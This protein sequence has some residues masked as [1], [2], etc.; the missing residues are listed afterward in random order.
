MRPIIAL[1]ACLSP[2]LAALPTSTVAAT[3]DGGNAREWSFKVFL[4]D[5]EIGYHD[6]RASTAGDGQHLESEA[7]FD[8]KILFVNAF[9]Y[10][11]QSRETWVGGC[12]NEI[13]AA[14]RTNGERKRVEGEDIGEQFRL[15]A[16]N[17]T[18][19]EAQRDAVPD[20]AASA[21]TFQSDCVSTFAYWDRSFLN[22]DRLLN[23]ETGELV[24]V[25]IRRLGTET[26]TVAGVQ[27]PVERYRID[28]PDGEIEVCYTRTGDRWEWVALESPIEGRMLR[29]VRQG[30]ADLPALMSSASIDFPGEEGR[31]GGAL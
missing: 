4:D 16:V 8:V 28:T 10:R 29:Y 17:L 22:K 6:F 26:I 19:K 11:H 23:P 24:P 5:R 15:R 31:S 25:E 12:L 7:Q 13:E 30:G 18:R 9:K 27:T 1:V 3:T 14:T 2:A 20:D 21:E